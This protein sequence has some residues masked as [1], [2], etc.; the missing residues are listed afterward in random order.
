MQMSATVD[1]ML[2]PSKRRRDAVRRNSLVQE[3]GLFGTSRGIIRESRRSSQPVC[4]GMVAKRRTYSAFR[5]GPDGR[6]RE[7]SERR[8]PKTGTLIDFNTHTRQEVVYV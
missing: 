1:Q 4:H 3:N 8:N 2:H 6:S 7:Q 5:D